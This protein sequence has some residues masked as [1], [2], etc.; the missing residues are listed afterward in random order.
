[1]SDAPSPW[2]QKGKKKLL[3]NRLFRLFEEEYEHPL[4]HRRGQFY[5]ME[6]ADWVQ[7]LAFDKDHHIIL[8]QQF[9]FGHGQLSLEAPGGLI[10]DGEDPVAA[11]ERELLEETGYAGKNAH[12]LVS[13][14]PNPAMQRNRLYI[15]IVEDCER[16]SAQHLDA[17]EEIKCLVM[18]FDECLDKLSSGEI[19]HG[20][21]R[22]AFLEYFFSQH[23]QEKK[24][25]PE[26]GIK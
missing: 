24:L 4:D 5:L 2:I 18:P 22:M 7:V 15:V 14:Y 21:A 3:S 6:T 17:N 26:R 12:L 19:N 25:L 16:V 20:I 9:R 23:N 8:V 10:D 1:M 11:A 13:I